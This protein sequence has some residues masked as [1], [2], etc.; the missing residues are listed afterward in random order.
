[1]LLR[2][3]GSIIG[4]TSGAARGYRPGRVGYSLSKAALERMLL[5]LAEEVRP[6]DVAVNA[7]SPGRVDT[8]MNRRGDWP[9]TGHIPLVPP[10]AVVPGA[11]KDDGELLYGETGMPCLPIALNSGLFWPRRSFMRKVKWPVNRALTPYCCSR[12]SP[13]P[14]A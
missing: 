4:I 14:T 13:H 10:D 8:W 9:G 7:L 1:M 3:S 2:R 12:G 5:S 6:A 11:T